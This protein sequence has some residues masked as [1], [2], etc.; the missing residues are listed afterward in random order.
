[1]DELTPTPGRTDPGGHPPRPDGD[2]PDPGG[3]PLGPGGHPLGPGGDAPG[4]G[5]GGGTDDAARLTPRVAP[6]S[7]QRRKNPMALVALVVVVAAL[8]VVVFSAL[9]DATLFFRNADEAV[10]QRADLGDRRFRLQGLVDGDTIVATARGV[11]FVVTYNGVDVTISYQ[12]DPPDLFQAGI[13]VVIEG[14]WAR[15]DDPGAF[16]PDA[17]LPTDDG[18]FFAGDRALVKH[19]EVYQEEHPDRVGDYDEGAE[20]AAGGTEA[21]PAR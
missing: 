7:R 20:G 4:P 3:H 12:G 18:W 13:P 6:A 5:P 16:S 11:D 19:T 21:G 17:S 10:A 15:V 14:R 9:G 1:M 2:A 8:G